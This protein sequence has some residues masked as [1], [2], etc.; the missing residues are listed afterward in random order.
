MRSSR[1]VALAAALVLVAA[2]ACGEEEGNEPGTEITQTVEVEAF[3]NYFEPTSLSVE[4]NA[5]VTVEFT[6]NGSITHSFTA[7]DLDVEIE[8]GNGEDGTV[9]FAVPNQPGSYDFFCKYH[10][11]EMQGTISAGGSEEPLEEDPDGDDDDDDTEV[12]VDVDED[13]ESTP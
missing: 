3:D 8:S 7:P 5:E 1:F 11:D 4:L 10:P 2:P 12:D 6:N 13:E 9:T